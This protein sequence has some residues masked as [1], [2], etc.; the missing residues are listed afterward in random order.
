MLDSHQSPEYVTP[1]QDSGCVLMQEA[2]KEFQTGVATVAHA[3]SHL[4]LQQR[5]YSFVR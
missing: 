2:F 1:T 5:S 3:Y 4:K